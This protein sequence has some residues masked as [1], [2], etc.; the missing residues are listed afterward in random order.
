MRLC[1]EWM[2][3]HATPSQLLT[4][5]DENE[6]IASTAQILYKCLRKTY[7]S[8]KIFIRNNY[9]E[10]RIRKS[11][12]SHESR[13]DKKTRNATLSANDSLTPSTSVQGEDPFGQHSPDMELIKALVESP[14]T[15]KLESYYELLSDIPQREICE[16][17]VWPIPCDLIPYDIFSTTFDNVTELTRH[18]Q[19]SKE[20]SHDEHS[21]E[22]E[23]FSGKENKPHNL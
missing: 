8:I 20:K 17:N 1:P 2:A 5:L 16:D 15:Q 9:E 11:P 22:A 14:Y 13:C 12:V 4:P 21:K 7:E 6:S 3:C 18:P 19:E 10:N 23:E